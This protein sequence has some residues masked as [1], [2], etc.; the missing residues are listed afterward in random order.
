M[1]D[2]TT[3][4]RIPLTVTLAPEHYAFVESCVELNEFESVDEIFAAALILYR[5]HVKALEAYA[6]DQSHKGYSRSELMAAIECETVVTKK[7][8][9]RKPRQRQRLRLRRSAVR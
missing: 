8:R 4:R 6:E 3:A 2:R 5:K 7:P 9:S 1:R